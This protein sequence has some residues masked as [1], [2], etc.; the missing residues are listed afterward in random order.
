MDFKAHFPLQQGSRHQPSPRPSPTVLPP[1]EYAP[2]TTVRMVQDKGVIRLHGQSY[3]VG[4]A[5]RGY[6]V[7][8]PPPL[9]TVQFCQETIAELDLTPP[10]A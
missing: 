4:Q 10:E 3:C 7:A 9:V 6:P 8:V 5:F 2:G 1:I